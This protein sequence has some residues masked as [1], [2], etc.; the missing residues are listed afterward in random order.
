MEVKRA[1]PRDGKVMTTMVYNP[2]Q[3]AMLSL[4]GGLMAHMGG[5]SPAGFATGI[6]YTGTAAFGHATMPGAIMQTL[7]PGLAQSGQIQKLICL[8]LIIILTSYL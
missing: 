5:L 7:P 1:E 4:S 2:A 6:P 3:L 8:P